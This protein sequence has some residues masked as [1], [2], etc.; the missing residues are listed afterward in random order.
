MP[1]LAA[2]LLDLDGTLVDTAE[3]N[4]AAYAAALGEVGVAV[5]R[6]SFDAVAN[7]RHWSQF[8]P[9][10]IG[11]AA[12]EPARVAARKRELYPAMAGRTRLNR[13]LA[14]FA[15]AARSR[16]KLALVTSASR[17]STVAVLNAHGLGQLFETVVTGD[18][19]AQPKPAPDAYLLAAER[20]EV[21]PDACLALEDSE[22]G[23]E[24]ARRAGMRTFRVTFPEGADKRTAPDRSGAAHWSA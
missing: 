10:I 1:E 24:S 6:A 9:G 21:S 8:L 15:A 23:L 14:D 17:S 4:Y 16:L 22:T 11:N 13:G 20:L 19:V 12:A 18:D 3:A 5:D 7:G 2:L